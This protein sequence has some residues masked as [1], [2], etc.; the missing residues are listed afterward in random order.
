LPTNRLCN[1]LRE[2]CKL[3][4]LSLRSL[5]INAGLSPGTVH[6]LLK[7]EYQPSLY[8]LN[9]LADYLAAPRPYLWQLA[10]F[11]DDMDYDAAI[12]IEDPQLKYHFSRINKLPAPAKALAMSLIEAVILYRERETRSE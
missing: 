6:N 5:S 12:T 4:G 2:Q 3:R 8:T 10:G 9:Q 11:L 1:Y 7:R